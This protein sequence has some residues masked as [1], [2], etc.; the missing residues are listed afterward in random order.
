MKKLKIF[1]GFAL[2][3]I[4]SLVSASAGNAQNVYDGVFDRP[5]FGGRYIDLCA[6]YYAVPHSTSNGYYVCYRGQKA[7]EIVANA[8][9]NKVGMKYAVRWKYVEGS[10]ENRKPVWK[11]SQN[12][13]IYEG[14][15]KSRDNQNSYTHWKPEEGGHYFTRIEC[16]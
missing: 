8:F 7:Q 15:S 14:G 4:V 13:N 3:W 11:L 12:A 9:C 6:S 10:W 2:L 1:S 16:R 5:S